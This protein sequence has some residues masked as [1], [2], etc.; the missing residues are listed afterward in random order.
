VTALANTG[1]SAFPVFFDAQAGPSKL[2][3]SA[4]GQQ[5]SDAAAPAQGSG[6]PFHSLVKSLS[7]GDDS[8]ATSKA[9]KKDA[10]DNVNSLTAN[11]APVQTP[12]KDTKP[13]VNWNLAAILTPSQIATPQEEASTLDEAGVDSGAFAS[14]GDPGTNPEFSSGEQTDQSLTQALNQ[15]ATQAA[16]LPGQPGYASGLASAATPPGALPQ[17]QTLA[18]AAVEAKPEAGEARTDRHG[19]SAN[20]ESIT[21]EAPDASVAGANTVGQPQYSAQ[22]ATLNLPP[23]D[24]NN[25]VEQLAADATPGTAQASQSAPA[26]S[27]SRGDAASMLAAQ[28][29][30]TRSKGS[31]P[32]AQAGDTAAKLDGK[33]KTAANRMKSGQDSASEAMADVSKALNLTSKAGEELGAIATVPQAK[34][35]EGDAIS[36][37]DA[38]TPPG[39]PR[40]G[41]IG[42]TEPRT[43]AMANGL[44][45]GTSSNQPAR[46]VNNVPN[47]SAAALQS[48]PVAFEGRLRQMNQET[49]A[50]PVTQTDT[51]QASAP[52]PLSAD[53]TQAFARQATVAPHVSPVDSAA[54]DQAGDS[55][56][57]Q[58]QQGKPTQGNAAAQFDE[59]APAARHGETQNAFSSTA[60]APAQP[61]NV[62][63]T[64][65]HAPAQATEHVHVPTLPEAEPTRVQ[66]LANNIRIA[67]DDNGQRVE[68]RLSERAGDIHVAVRTP[69]SQLAESL[70]GDLPSLSS[71]LEQSGYHSEMWKPTHSTSSE[72]RLPNMGNSNLSSDTRQQSGGRQQDEGSQQ[73]RQNPKNPQQQMLNR[74]S[75]RKEFSW[76][77]QSIR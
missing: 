47:S 33:K 42:A 37:P 3:A 65:E 61:A 28:A 7:G 12:V 70:R 53:S 64:R 30:E 68:L 20:Q 22:P 24:A 49:D 25:Q 45:P 40:A 51:K 21:G 8:P 77:V 43:D 6:A 55:D 39:H 54:Q 56:G 13:P 14:K 66:P 46:T 62:S 76:L 4:A 38:S 50:A 35:S 23:A 2:A 29:A 34:T 60:T 75:D 71:K 15:S 41:A 74:K 48:A 52:R 1:T 17:V 44:N 27:L 19:R 67:L 5:A 32:A 57:S 26:A 16:G 18:H 10:P 69:D 59:M 11:L 73:Q 63:A 9:A 36:K 58:G 31:V 72:M